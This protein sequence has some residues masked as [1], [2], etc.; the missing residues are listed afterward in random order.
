MVRMA[1]ETEAL[2]REASWCWDAAT[3]HSPVPSSIIREVMNQLE[4]PSNTRKISREDLKRKCDRLLLTEDVSVRIMILLAMRTMDYFNSPR[5]GLIGTFL[6]NH[7]RAEIIEWE[8]GSIIGEEKLSFQANRLLHR[9]LDL[10]EGSISQILQDTE[11]WRV[12][13]GLL[14]E[15]KD[16]VLAE[17]RKL[18]ALKG[19]ELERGAERE[20]KEHME[21]LLAQIF[22]IDFSHRRKE[23]VRKNLRALLKEALSSDNPEVFCAITRFLSSEAGRI[24]PVSWILELTPKKLSAYLESLV[25]S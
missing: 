22:N 17:D 12:C 18:A 25:I 1:D 5:I 21:N 6:A 24:F 7:E 10:K 16:P 23:E 14:G 20:M 8:G 15:V 2:R 9:A 19:E 3:D 4:I 13:W 11:T